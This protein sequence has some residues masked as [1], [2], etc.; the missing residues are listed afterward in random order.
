MKKRSL[1]IVLA[2][3]SLISCESMEEV[4]N[5]TFDVLNTDLVINAG[6]TLSF[7]F[8]GTA[9]VV[10]FYSGEFGHVYEY[11]DRTERP[12]EGNLK[13]SFTTSVQNSYAIEPFPRELDVFISSD[14]NG[15]LDYANVISE[16][17][18]WNN[19][20]DRFT[21]PLTSANGTLA[22]VPI[23]ASN[24]EGKLDITELVEI[25]KSFYIAFRY[26]AENRMKVG[27]NT[28]NAREWRVDALSLINEQ[29]EGTSVLMSQSSAGWTFVN[30]AD[31]EIEPGRGGSL[32]ST[33]RISIRGNQLSTYQPGEGI[34]IWAIST[35]INTGMA[36]TEPDR[37][38]T[39]KNISRNRLA[40][41]T[42]VY[43]KPGVYK[44]VFVAANSSI[45]GHQAVVKEVNVRVNP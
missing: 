22:A 17:S 26:K 33:G 1:I 45:Y 35:P 15:N 21:F 27:S 44:A 16:S 19:I 20:S 10:T 13:I 38:T 34:E 12:F 25:G 24:P 37:G 5:P 43:N 41:H 18:K 29:S 3:L 2:I 30:R 6:D 4:D 14:F 28:R 42:H 36:K 11:K 9:D 8:K 32:N 40:S 39:I 23:T 31:S 7:D